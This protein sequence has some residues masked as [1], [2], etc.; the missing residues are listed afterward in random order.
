QVICDNRDTLSDIDAAIGDGDHGINMA[1]GFSQ[2]GKRLDEAGDANLVAA[3]GALSESLLDGI[4][5][6]MGPLYGSFF[7]SFGEVL[8]DRDVLDAEAFS[9]ALHEGMSSIQMLGE[10]EVGDKTLLDTLAPAVEAFDT[11]H[12]TDADFPAALAAMCAA[13][14][15]GKNSTKDLQARLGRAARLGERS[16]GTIDAGATSCCLILTTMATSI[17][18]RLPAAA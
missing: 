12:T 17:T 4:G 3:L 5:G 18:Q 1:K 2:C 9:A 7:M 6:S 13:A 11:A 10:A 16:I 14:E 8:E 15:T